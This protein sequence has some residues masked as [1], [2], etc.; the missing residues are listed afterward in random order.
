[1]PR[2]PDSSA[3]RRVQ[4]AAL[5]YRQRQDGEVQ[6]RLITSRETRRWVLPKGWPMKD[7]APHKAAAREAFEEAGLIGNTSPNAIG[8]YTYE[9]RLSAV[10]SV[11]CDVMVFPMKVK[12]YLKKWPERSQ[13]IG[14]WFTVESAAAAV[15]EEDL[16]E[17]I[18]RF[19]AIMADRHAAKEAAK[20]ARAAEVAEAKAA[21]AKVAD[22]KA[23]AAKAVAS[24]SA[25]SKSAASKSGDVPAGKGSGSGSGSGGGKKPAV[26]ASKGTTRE[27]SKSEAGAA[28][29]ISLSMEGGLPGLGTEVQKASEKA[30]GGKRKGGAVKLRDADVLELAGVARPLPT[31]H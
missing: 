5:P 21:E 6:V 18:L 27:R 11:T 24:K 8:L 25:A 12:R 22:A 7:I 20:Q 16:K 1:M 30:K 28:H 4:Y 14:F 19:G 23:G 3:G 31:T 29:A 9:K 10:R 15:Q 2:P 26:E 13:R 17:L